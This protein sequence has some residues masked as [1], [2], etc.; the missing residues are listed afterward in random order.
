[1]IEIKTD[2]RAALTNILVT[3]IN[4]RLNR[5]VPVLLLASGGSTASIAAET[6]NMILEGSGTRRSL[7]RWLFTL[8]LV[9][10]RFGPEDHPDSNWKRLVES[11]LITSSMT[12][13]RV[14]HGQEDSKEAFTH[15]TDRY[16]AFLEE[17]AVRHKAGHLY[18]AAVMGIGS[19]G[20]TAGILPDSPVSRISPAGSRYAESYK[21]GLFKRITITPAFFPH[22]DRVVV[23]AEGEEKRGALTNL[24]KESPVWEEPA[25]LL[26]LAGHVTIHT[27]LIIE[28]N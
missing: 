10:E 24:L 6:C 22:L 26:K 17:A 13:V 3:E 7:L 9:D 18:T 25:Q 20:H 14:L 2:T 19:D 28:G 12:A 23:W 21:A 8:S 11:G 4:D 1:M 5:N 27:D 15:E 16:N